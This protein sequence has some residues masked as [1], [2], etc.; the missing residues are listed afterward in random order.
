MVV[1]RY[2]LVEELKTPLEAPRCFELIKER[3]HSFFL[4]SGMDPAKLGRYSFMGADPFL[5]LKS[6]GREI[7]LSYG[8]GRQETVKGNPFDVLGGLLSAT[9]WRPAPFPFLLSAAPSAI[10]ATTCATL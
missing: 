7:G 4:D 8:D 9:G 10:S 2:P 5:V 6:R 3:P 1:K